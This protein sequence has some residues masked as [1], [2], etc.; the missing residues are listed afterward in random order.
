MTLGNQARNTLKLLAVLGGLW[1]FGQL[2]V[3]I[4]SNLILFGGLLAGGVFAAV[5][6]SRIFAVISYWP[7]T[8]L[9]SVVVVYLCRITTEKSLNARLGIEIEYLNHAPVL[10]GALYSIAFSLMLVGLYLLMPLRLRQWLPARPATDTRKLPGFEPFFAT[11]LLCAALYAHQQL[12]KGLEFALIADAVAVSSCGPPEAGT[13]YLRKNHEQC[14]ALQGNPLIGTFT[15]Q[16]LD[17]K[18]P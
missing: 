7:G 17:S 3:N 8:L 10:Y 2:P 14:Y 16:A 5:N 18:A 15:V 13:L 1:G 11:A 9:Y 6:L 4:G 12:D